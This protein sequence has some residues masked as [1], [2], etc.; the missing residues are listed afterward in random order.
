MTFKILNNAIGLTNLFLTAEILR[1]A[2]ACQIDERL[3]M[4]SIEA[5]SGRNFFSR[6]FEETIKTYGAYAGTTSGAAGIALLS[7]KDME[8]ALDLARS[9]GTNAPILETLAASLRTYPQDLIS[10]GWRDIATK[11]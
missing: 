2:G 6:N 10:N 7:T 9:N 5:G 8:M 1:L 11:A 3:L 4:S